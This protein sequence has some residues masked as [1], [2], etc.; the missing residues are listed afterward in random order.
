VDV[1]NQSAVP[2][3]FVSQ[4]VGTS[5]ETITW[6]DNYEGVITG[7]SCTVLSGDSPVHVFIRN[8]NG[9]YLADIPLAGA[10]SR[11]DGSYLQDCFI[12][13]PSG[14]AIVV[15]CS[16]ATASLVV[17]GWLLTPPGSAIIIE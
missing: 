13:I 10:G 11:G 16:I 5:A 8:G 3:Q 7:L 1:T 12:V 15:S 2:Y 17:S 14:S 4:T 9:D 6:P